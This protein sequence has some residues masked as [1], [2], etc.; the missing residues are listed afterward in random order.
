MKFK[1]F[2][3]ICI[4]L[5][6]IFTC[7]KR[8]VQK[9]EL[10]FW[11]L[12]LGTFDK[13]INSVISNFE[14][15]NPNIKIKWVDVPYSE[16]EKRTLAALLSD[17]PPD[18]I[19]LT[20][21]FSAMAAQKNA[22]FEIPQ[23]VMNNFPESLYQSLSYNGKFFAIPF[24]LTSAITFANKDLMAKASIIRV[25]KTYDEMF[26]CAKAA[27]KAGVY[28]EMPSVNEN[29][30]FLKILNKYNVNVYENINSDI[31]HKI[32]DM[33]SNL[34]KNDLIPKESITQ[35]HREA[36]EKYMAGQ[37]IFLQAGANFLNIVKENAPSIYENTVLA[38]QMTGTTNKYDFSLM[39]LIIPTK[40][41]H[42]EDALKFAAF[43]TNEQNQLEFAK[44]T[45]VL[46][47]NKYAL[48]DDY[49]KQTNT[50]E[51][52]ARKLSAEQIKN[53][54]SGIQNKRNKK[55]IILLVNSCLARSMADKTNLDDD[56][57]QL[58]DKI[59]DFNE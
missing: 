15:Q 11:T 29:D 48:E 13:Y 23:D 53:V 21:D 8:D 47:A 16:G 26:S 49:F 12:Q 32:F 33:Y 57:E 18:L 7:L 52:I 24:Y 30:T 3:T 35:S 55:N 42:R 56:L 51:D 50:K 5:T 6:V 36:L 25:P 39:N 27:R 38:N 19:N 54:T 9:D 10:V 34:Y 20:P 43:L 37:I 31:S 22:L 41:K 28:I 17:N 4:F 44:L 40:A 45:S 59:E 46:P 58:Q 14:K 2:A 1:I